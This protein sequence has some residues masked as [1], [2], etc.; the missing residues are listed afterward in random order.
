MMIAGRIWKDASW[1]LAESEIADVVTQGKTRTEAAAMLADATE[2]LVDRSRFKVTVRDAPSAG[3]G[4]VT[5]EAND[6]AALVA[7]VLRRQ[8][9]ASGLSLADVVEKL[10][11]TSKTAYARYEQGDAMPS[12]EKF[13][14]L[15]RAVSPRAAVV[16][17]TQA[18]PSIPRSRTK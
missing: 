14:E 17:G 2:S 15:L 7:L 16:I 6:P 1:W 9:Q 8:R 18:R 11:Q 12:M 10:G 4:G 5:I 3:N 13:E